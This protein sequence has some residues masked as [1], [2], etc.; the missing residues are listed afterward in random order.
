MGTLAQT[1]PPFKVVEATEELL[2]AN[3]G[4]ALFGEFASK[5]FLHPLDVRGLGFPR[6]LKQEMPKPGSGRGYIAS[7]CVKPLV[8]MLAGGGEPSRMTP[9]RPAC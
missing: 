7:F 6:W 8:L 4:L 3:A 1:V 5:R 2:A 9:R